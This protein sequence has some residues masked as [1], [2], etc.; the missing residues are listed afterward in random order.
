MNSEP[1]R[2]EDTTNQRPSCLDLMI[3][4]HPDKII[5]HET[6]PGFSDHTLQ[7][8]I[9]RSSEII[10]QPQ[11]IKIRSYKNYSNQRYKDNIL[12]H[13]L[14]IETLHEKNPETITENIQK[15]I[16][17]SLEAEAPVIKKKK[18]KKMKQNCHKK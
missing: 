16:G 11:I 12:N 13:Y 1:T 3:T 6:L 14:Y 7:K 15:I 5:R 17:E 2:Y 4:N 10:T 9:R 18:K 8:L